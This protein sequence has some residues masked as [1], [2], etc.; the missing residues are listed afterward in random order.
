MTCFGILAGGLG[1]RFGE[2]K[3]SATYGDVTFLDHCLAIVDQARRDEDSVA[4]SVAHGFADA[5]G[6]LTDRVLVRDGS[7]SPGPAHS[8]GRLAEYASSRSQDLVFMA[9]DM[10]AVTPSTLAA[11]ARRLVVN[12]TNNEDMIVVARNGGR[13]HWVLGGIPRTL[14]PRV[15]SAAESVSAVQS[16][17]R[18]SQ[19]DYLDVEPPELIDVNFPELLPDA[20]RISSS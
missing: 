14:L 11:I 10:L 1:T 5:N 20:S 3:I 6:A 13:A 18:L 16:L 2:P 17:L 9:V 7:P 15:V 19:L 8:I 4:V 12:Q